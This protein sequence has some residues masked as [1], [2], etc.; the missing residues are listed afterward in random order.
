MEVRSIPVS[1][2]IFPLAHV[3]HG[4]VAVHVPSLDAL[5]VAVLSRELSPSVLGFK[6]VLASPLHHVVK[7]LAFVDVAARK[8]VQAPS[9]PLVV[10][11]VSYVPVPV[12]VHAHALSVRL[13]IPPLAL[14]AQSAHVRHRAASV[15]LVIFPLAIV[16][17]ARAAPVHAFPVPSVSRDDFAFVRISVRERQSRVEH[18]Q[19]ESPVMRVVR[20]RRL[21]QVQVVGFCAVLDGGLDVRIRQIILLPGA[22][23][24][25]TT[26]TVVVPLQERIHPF[27]VREVVRAV[28]TRLYFRLHGSQFGPHRR[29]DLLI[30]VLRRRSWRRCRSRSCC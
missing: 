4:A 16:E 23:I 7:P 6:V 30:M 26:T 14:V 10:L 11:P 2:T 20:R 17:V 9:P 3:F 19:R 29:Q 28:G 5:A 22:P 12:L 21:V 13:V 8:L 15:S 1:S 24:T 18:G 25:T 27:P